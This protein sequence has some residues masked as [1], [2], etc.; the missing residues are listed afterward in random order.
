MKGPGVCMLM[1]FV[2]YMVNGIFM[3]ISE[4]VSYYMK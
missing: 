4:Q 3:D 1:N 2:F